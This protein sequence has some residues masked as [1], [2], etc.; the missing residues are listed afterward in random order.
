M[1]HVR[2]TTGQLIS[3]I[4]PPLSKTQNTTSSLVHRHLLEREAEGGVV[5]VFCKEPLYSERTCPSSKKLRN[6]YY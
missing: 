1:C 5:N 3:I 2:E 6:L 4:V